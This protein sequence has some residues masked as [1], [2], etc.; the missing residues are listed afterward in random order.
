MT[1]TYL[2]GLGSNRRGR[3]GL[4]ADEVRAALVAIGAGFAADTSAVNQVLRPAASPMPQ[5]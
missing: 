5:R 4:P 1:A 2:I 3:H